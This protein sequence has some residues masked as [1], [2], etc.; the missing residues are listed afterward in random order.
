MVRL[1]DQQQPRKHKRRRAAQ[2]GLMM[3]L[4]EN[5]KA[6]FTKNV[7]GSCPNGVQMPIDMSQKTHTMTTMPGLKRTRLNSV[8]PRINKSDP[9]ENFWCPSLRS[10]GPS[11]ATM[12]MMVVRN[13]KPGTCSL[14][15]NNSK[16]PH[17]SNELNHGQ[18]A[19]GSSNAIVGG[20]KK[21]NNGSIF[22]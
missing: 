13:T 1:I 20:C 9:S 18:E 5:R 2:Q 16:Q 17:Q 12:T 22:L 4:M 6:L 3:V 15:F 11:H 10:H 21:K 19:V 7:A 8:R 14:F